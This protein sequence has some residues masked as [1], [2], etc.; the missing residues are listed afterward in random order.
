LELIIE[1]ALSNAQLELEPLKNDFHNK[2]L[3]IEI[4][5]LQWVL[6]QQRKIFNNLNM[7]KEIVQDEIYNLRITYN[8]ST[9]K[10]DINILSKAIEILEICLYLIKTELELYPMRKRNNNNNNKTNEN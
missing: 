8:E 6:N 10:D 1:K 7:L 5:I 3:L 4:I 9:S 2:S